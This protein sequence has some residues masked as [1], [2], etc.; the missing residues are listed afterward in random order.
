MRKNYQTEK[1]DTSQ[2]AVPD[3]VSVALGELAGGPPSLRTRQAADS[4][5]RPSVRRM[6]STPPACSM[7][8][9]QPPDDVVHLPLKSSDQVAD[10]VD[11]YVEVRPMLTDSQP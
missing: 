7:T 6:P 9:H 1:I 4:A 3:T 2:P 5:S 8:Y 10:L 11:A